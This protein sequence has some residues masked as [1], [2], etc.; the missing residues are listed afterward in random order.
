MNS[1][2]IWDWNGTILNDV[3][4]AVDVMNALL[5]KHDLPVLDVPRY[6]KLF[7]FP[8]RA[9]YQDLGFS[10]EH[11]EFLEVANG[12]I[13]GF[14][15]GIR[16]CDLRGSV[17]ATLEDLKGRGASQSILSAAKQHSLRQQV[18]HHGIGHFFDDVLGLDNHYAAGKTEVG[19]AWVQEGRHPVED[20]VFVGDTCHDFEVA[21]AMGVSCILVADGHQSRE[22]LEECGCPIIDSIEALPSML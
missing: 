9:Y 22:R 2:I 19:L 7:R 15:A 8:V 14:E 4:H 16:D 6:R 11:E 17:R 18:E 20:T 21:Q 13:E 5:L 3:T 12:F 1:H 10:D